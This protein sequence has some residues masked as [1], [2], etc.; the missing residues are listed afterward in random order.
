MHGVGAE[1]L[2]DDMGP[3]DFRGDAGV[4]VVL[5]ETPRRVLGQPQ[6]ADP[7]LRIGERRRHRVPAI[8]H[9]TV[10]PLAAPGRLALGLAGLGKSLGKS[11]WG[12]AFETGLVF[13]IAHACIIYP[14]FPSARRARRVTTSSGTA[15]FAPG[16]RYIYR[17]AWLTLPAQFPHKRA[18]PQALDD[19]CDIQRHDR[20]DLPLAADTGQCV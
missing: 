14:S 16:G 19:A 10:R 3:D 9:R 13:A 18:R 12:S 20:P 15:D 2:V 4:D 11:G 6:F 8:E 1:A 5:G 17:A 7:A